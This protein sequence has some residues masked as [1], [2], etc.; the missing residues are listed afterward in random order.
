MHHE[1]GEI[2]Q[3]LDSL[4]EQY[5]KEIDELGHVGEFHPR[6]RLD[7]HW[8]RSRAEASTCLLADLAEPMRA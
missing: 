2:H 6:R 8:Q 1:L 3:C 5:K 7:G 4:D